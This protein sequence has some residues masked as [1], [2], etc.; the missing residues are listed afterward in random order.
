MKKI[1]FNDRYGLTDAV[2]SGRKTVT[3]R[4]VSEKVWEK[5]T[6]YDDYCNSVG[7]GDIPTTRQY[8]TCQDFFADHSPYELGD[9]VAVA[10]SYRDA[11]IK[12]EM[13]STKVRE[14]LESKGDP[15]KG[16]QI[17]SL[18]L[19]EGYINKMFVRA[20]LM[21]HQIK[22]TDIRVEKLQDITDD[23]CLREGIEWLHTSRSFY[24]NWNTITGS[25]IYLGR[26]PREAFAALI[27]KVSGK[28]TWDR[29]PYVWRI[30]FELIK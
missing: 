11:F 20:D 8:C 26:T 14:F 9:I 23:D 21:P 28:G 4:I 15:I 18:P 24:T 16:E 13:E 19:L 10:Q 17:I 29:N 27:D 6:D 12:S 5:W 1:M 30:E 7:I 25:R 3:R 22:I 2:L